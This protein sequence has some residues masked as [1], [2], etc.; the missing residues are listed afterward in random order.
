MEKL[1][2]VGTSILIITIVI[3]LITV[4]IAPAKTYAQSSVFT[5]LAKSYVRIGNSSIISLVNSVAYVTRYSLVIVSIPG[6]STYWS[7]ITG[8]AMLLAVGSY[9]KHPAFTILNLSNLMART[10]YISNLRGSLYDC[11]M[12]KSK[13]VCVGYAVFNDTYSGLIVYAEVP[14]ASED[15]INISKVKVLICSHACYLR[16]ILFLGD[17]YLLVGGYAYG[18]YYTP[19]F[20]NYYLSN[21]R[22]GNAIANLFVPKTKLFTNYP[23]IGLVSDAELINNYLVVG[24][25]S[26]NGLAIHFININNYLDKC[27]F[28][29]EL[30]GVSDSTVL[31]VTSKGLV[32][33]V[34]EIIA[35]VM[36]KTCLIRVSLTGS[37]GYLCGIHGIHVDVSKGVVNIISI[38]GINTVYPSLLTELSMD[39]CSL[40]HTETTVKIAPLKATT[41]VLKERA[42]MMKYNL[43]ST[44]ISRRST[45]QSPTEI[46]GISYTSLSTIPS[47]IKVHKELPNT[48]YLVIGCV[49]L[50]TYLIIRLKLFRRF[51][52][53]R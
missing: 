16:R 22:E 1:K 35:T 37:S 46:T 44:N 50:T 13:L 21:Y 10:T 52:L 40:S 41:S 20:M 31:T 17:G 33:Q 28:S 9:L 32:L 6:I 19:F 53:R 29:R 38:K 51:R 23:C 4:C 43:V 48:A 3:A 7:N 39:G 12:L 36:G 5:S 47:F 18:T 11:V 27:Y 42:V 30:G 14:R 49:L 8:N 15:L 25:R 45:I 2:V 34:Y 24:I 26:D